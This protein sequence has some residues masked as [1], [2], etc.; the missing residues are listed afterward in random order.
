MVRVP[1][2]GGDVCIHRYEARLEGDAGARDGS[3]PPPRPPHVVAEAGALPTSGVCWYRARAACTAV[4]Y[5]LC[6]CAEWEDACDGQAGPGGDAFPTPSGLPTPSRCPIAGP[7]A[8]PAPSP[9]G[10]WPLCRTRTG[11]FDLAGNL[12][13]WC[14]P[15]AS[16]EAGRPLTDKR[17]G[18]HYSGDWAACSQAAVGAHP[19]TF[20]GTIGFRC[21]VAASPP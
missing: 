14:D 16:D 6:T 8:P 18:A 11:I 5:H 19:P 21:C 12:W 9:S 1:T 3:C 4:G 17:G 13:E 2:V 10:A 20:E 15:G 7:W